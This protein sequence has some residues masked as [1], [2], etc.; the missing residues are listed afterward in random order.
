MTPRILPYLYSWQ[1]WRRGR[2][3]HGRGKFCRC[4]W[5]VTVKKDLIAGKYDLTQVRRLSF[6]MENFHQI[7]NGGYACKLD[8]MGR[9]EIK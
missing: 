7:N 9:T 5:G 6:A 3:C 8:A 2:G 4:P 1:C